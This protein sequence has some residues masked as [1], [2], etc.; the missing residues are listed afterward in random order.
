MTIASFVT[1][2]VL[3]AM[4]LPSAKAAKTDASYDSEDHCSR[5]N[6]TPTLYSASTAPNATCFQLTDGLD[7]NE[8]NSTTNSSLCRYLES[9][10][11]YQRVN[12]VPIN[13]LMLVLD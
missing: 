6:G 11:L 1:F 13:T 7:M 8:T 10:Y 4:V 12:N 2:M 3:I 5:A 9:D